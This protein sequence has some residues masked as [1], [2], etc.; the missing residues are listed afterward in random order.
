MVTFAE[1][2]PVAA[3]DLVDEE[4]EEGEEGE[5]DAAEVAVNGA[6]AKTST[7]VV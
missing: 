5:E 1:G 7:A 2:D 6:H 3:E 4:G